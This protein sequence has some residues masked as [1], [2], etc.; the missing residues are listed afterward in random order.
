MSALI[1]SVVFGF[2]FGSGL[3]PPRTFHDRFFGSTMR[4]ALPHLR[5]QRNALQYRHW[6]RCRTGRVRH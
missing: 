4:E 6:R 5:H 2:G 1:F 3:G